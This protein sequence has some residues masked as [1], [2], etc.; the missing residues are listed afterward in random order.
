MGLPELNLTVQ[1]LVFRVLALLVIVTVQ[2]LLVAAL[3][4]LL[5]D[6]GPRYD[7][8]LTLG[9][10]SH[11]DLVGAFSLVLFGNGWSKPVDVDPRELGTGRAG[12]VLI[13]VGAFAGLLALAA[14]LHWL[15]L[16]A[17]TALPHTAALSAAAFLR[18]ASGLTIWVALLSLVPVPPLTGG[19]LLRAAGFRVPKS[20]LPILA[21][22]LAAAV[23][24]GVVR[25]VAGQAHAVLTAILTG[26]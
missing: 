7:G 10:A 20:A 15:I 8:R 14:L 24:T 12:L 19:L 13:V 22:I 1:L 9:P 11:I 18:V 16:P 21:L 17:V 23:A 2:G 5:G 4:V 3:A 6:R 25:E 26:H